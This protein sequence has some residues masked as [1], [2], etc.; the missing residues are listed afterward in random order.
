MTKIMKIMCLLISM[1]LICNNI[2]QANSL[3]ALSPTKPNVLIILADD[4]GFTDIG[5]YGSEIA[6]PNI[7][8]LASTGL[9]FSQFYNTARC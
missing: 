9:S 1:L 3:N 6:T 2:V 5:A 8:A 7:D 4:L